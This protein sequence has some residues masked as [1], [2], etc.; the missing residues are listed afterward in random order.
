MNDRNASGDHARRLVEEYV[1]LEERRDALDDEDAQLRE[2]RRIVAEKARALVER[3]ERIADVLGPALRTLG[4]VHHLTNVGVMYAV[5]DV[6][7]EPLPSVTRLSPAGSLRLPP[8]FTA[9]EIREAAFDAAANFVMREDDGEIEDFV[10]GA[11]AKS[12]LSHLRS[13]DGRKASILNGVAV[14]DQA[15]S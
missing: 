14:P 2:E 11:A 8:R 1:A 9:D 13:R 4:P 12:L 3:Q 7:G 5:A 10:V 15:A 6:P